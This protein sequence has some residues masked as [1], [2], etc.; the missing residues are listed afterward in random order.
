MFT[1][2]K[3]REKNTILQIDLPNDF[4]KSIGSNGVY[5]SI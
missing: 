1:S 3:I 2:F 5:G 4:R